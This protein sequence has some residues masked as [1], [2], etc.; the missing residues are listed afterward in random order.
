VINEYARQQK[1]SRDKEELSLGHRSRQRNEL[2]DTTATP[3]QRQ[4]C[5]RQSST[6][7][8]YQRELSGSGIIYF[9]RVFAASFA[10]S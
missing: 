2:R 5:L 1:R 4:R 8:E 7:G 9:E 10:N 3:I 6:S